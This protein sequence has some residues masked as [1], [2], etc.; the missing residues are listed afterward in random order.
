MGLMLLL[1]RGTNTRKLRPTLYDFLAHRAL[2]FF[3]NDEDGVTKP[4]YQFK[5]DD[6]KA[7][8]NADE[9]IFKSFATKDTA[10][11][12]QKALTLFQE[13]LKFHIADANP[14]ALIDADLIR[15]DF[16]NNNA[17]VENK[18]KLYEEALLSIEKKYPQN[19]A[20]AQAMYLRGNIYLSRGQQFKPFVKTENQY[21]IKRAKELFEEAFARFPK[22]EGGINAKNAIVQIEQPSLNIETEKVNIPLQPFRSLVTYKNIKTIYLRVIKTSREE[23]KKFD[24]RDYEKLWKDIR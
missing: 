16:V 23:I 15:L 2:V 18:E 13:L 12:Q 11:L 22:S 19:P 6:A 9:F 5:I 8:A 4:A 24:R 3:M 20:I 7:F 21:E 1:L 17:V 14:D 10:S